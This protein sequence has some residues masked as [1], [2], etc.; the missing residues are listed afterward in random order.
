M[1]LPRITRRAGTHV[2]CVV[3]YRENLG[4]AVAPWFHFVNNCW[5]E[6]DKNEQLTKSE[7]RDGDDRLPLGR[8]VSLCM[9]TTEYAGCRFAASPAKG[10]PLFD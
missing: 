10:A 8:P 2:L 7:G 3:C 1:G 6:P 9:Y 4:Y 5:V